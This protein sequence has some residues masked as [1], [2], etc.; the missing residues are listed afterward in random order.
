[1]GVENNLS[2]LNPLGT[3]YTLK[4]SNELYWFKFVFLS[5]LACLTNVGLF[6]GPSIAKPVYGRLLAIDTLLLTKGSEM[7]IY[8][9]LLN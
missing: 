7:A 8:L 1:M 3:W 4:C 6:Q 2:I 5:L 9:N